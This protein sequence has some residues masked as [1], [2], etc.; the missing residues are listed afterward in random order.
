MS[1]LKVDE[2]LD[3]T[4]STTI[5]PS[6]PALEHRLMKVRCRFSMTTQ[7][8]RNSEGVS[9]ITDLGIGQTR[10]NFSTERDSTNYHII[11]STGV[12]ENRCTS[13]ENVLTTSCTVNAFIAST[14]ALIDLTDAGIATF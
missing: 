3:S 11:T 14:G 4:G 10:V 5:E 13:Y 9:S 7:T 6:I 1:T 2:I 8:I 12:I